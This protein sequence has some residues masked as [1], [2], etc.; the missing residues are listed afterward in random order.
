MRAGCAH[1]R[2]RPPRLPVSQSVLLVNKGQCWLRKAELGPLSPAAPYKI[3]AGLHRPDQLKGCAAI[4]GCSYYGS[5]LQICQGVQWQ[6]MARRVC[7]RVL[8]P[9]HQK[10]NCVSQSVV[11]LGK[12]G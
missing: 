7:P 12:L 1:W 11:M 5:Q 3:W 9:T 8:H 6:I 2:A 10:R 4:D